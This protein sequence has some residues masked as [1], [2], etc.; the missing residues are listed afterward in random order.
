MVSS[1]VLE[2]AAQNNREKREREGLSRAR[3]W[4]RKWEARGFS[5]AWN[6]IRPAYFLNPSHM[7]SID[8]F[9][10][11]RYE[12]ADLADAGSGN[13]GNRSDEAS[14]SG[15]AGLRRR[16]TPETRDPTTMASGAVNIE[17][18]RGWIGRTESRDD[19]VWPGPVAALSATLDRNDPRPK[20]GDLLPLLW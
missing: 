3:N 2:N 4:L 8:D 13:S 11:S 20:A 17:S 19:V 10:S 7:C 12:L 1:I 6:Q 16:G 15:D 9:G 5:R 14:R 18:L